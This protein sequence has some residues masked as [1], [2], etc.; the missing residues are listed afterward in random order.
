[1]KNPN[2]IKTVAKTYIK[3]VRTKNS[4]GSRRYGVT[5][6]TADRGEGGARA[7]ARAAAREAVKA[8][9]DCELVF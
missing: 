2:T 6:R 1:M 5:N 7:A 4:N 8:E 9:H 3:A